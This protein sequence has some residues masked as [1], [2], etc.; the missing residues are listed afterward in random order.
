MIQTR[1]KPVGAAIYMEERRPPVLQI[2]N[3]SISYQN[4]PT[5]K[6]LSLQVAPGEILGIVG[7]S[8][9][10]KSTLLKSILGLLGDGGKVTDG[11]ILFDGKS[12][13]TMSPKALQQIRGKEIALIFQHPEASFDPTVRIRR[14]FYE[15]AKIHGMSSKTE[16]DDRIRQLLKDMYFEDPDRILD[17][18]PFELSGGMCQRVAIAMAMLHKPRLLLA[19][20][21]TSALDVTVQAQVVHALMELRKNTGC[22]ILLVTHNM[23]VAAHMSD[24]IGVMRQG[25][26]VEC[27]ECKKVLHTPEHDYTKALI[28]A[29]PKMDGT[30]PGGVSK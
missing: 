29:I 21:P 16:T 10:G 17:M 14:Q 5:V 25:E 11:Q 8:G 12:L 22:A 27:G 28:R 13:Q 7:E 23:G 1:E 26:L 9:S 15:C 18:Y 6:N 3:I 19:D 24:R 30:L 2:K 20:E 4:R